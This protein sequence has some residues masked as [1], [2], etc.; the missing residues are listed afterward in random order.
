[1][2]LQAGRMVKFGPTAEVIAWSQQNKVAAA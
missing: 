1:M 2:V